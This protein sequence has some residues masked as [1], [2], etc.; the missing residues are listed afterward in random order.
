M[1]EFNYTMVRNFRKD[2]IKP[3]ELNECIWFVCVDDLIGGWLISNANKSA[4]KLNPYKGEF[5][6]GSFMMRETAEHIV[7]LHN[8][9]W[10]QIVDDSYAD[11]IMATWNREID[12]HY[13]GILDRTDEVD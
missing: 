6:I 11:N 7:K 10:N 3:N 8:Q 5:E 9:W 12:E 1:G 4:A 13:Q 2:P